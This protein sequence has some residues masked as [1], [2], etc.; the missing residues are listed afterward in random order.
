MG[1][2]TLPEMKSHATVINC[3]CEITYGVKTGYV[4]FKIIVK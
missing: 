2:F 3:F 1:V 4:I